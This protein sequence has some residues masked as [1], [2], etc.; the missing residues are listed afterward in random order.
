MAGPL[1]FTFCTQIAM[2]VG[3]NLANR[4]KQKAE[5]RTIKKVSKRGLYGNREFQ[6]PFWSL[7][8]EALEFEFNVIVSFRVELYFQKQV[9]QGRGWNVKC[10]FPNMPLTSIFLIPASK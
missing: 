2:E 3:L 1:F 10:L 5:S 4:H 9:T 7:I 6:V 8:Y